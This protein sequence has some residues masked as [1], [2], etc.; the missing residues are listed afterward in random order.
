MRILIPKISYFIGCVTLGKSPCLSEPLSTSMQW[1]CGE[2]SRRH[3]GVGHT[4]G[5]QLTAP[6]PIPGPLGV[7]RAA[8]SPSPEHRVLARGVEDQAGV[9]VTGQLQ[10]GVHLPLPGA[11]GTAAGET[12]GRKQAVRR[13]CWGGGAGTLIG[14]TALCSRRLPRSPSLAWQV[15]SRPRPSRHPLGTVRTHGQGL[16]PLPHCSPGRQCPL[17][18]SSADLRPRYQQ[19]MWSLSTSP[20]PSTRERGLEEDREE[21]EP[22]CSEVKYSD[23]DP[24]REG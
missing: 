11:P 23:I 3:W 16:G 2:D 10:G 14:R 8:E 20:P 4:V 15:P 5:V 24:L 18:A 22:A 13:V 12:T 1:D 7:P 9:S 17:R 6:S 19:R 21:G